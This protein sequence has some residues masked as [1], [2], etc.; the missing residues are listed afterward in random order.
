MPEIK[1]VIRWKS[2]KE[3]E[4]V[5]ELR[6]EDE[7]SGVYM[8]TGHHSVSGDD[9]L[10]YIGVAKDSTFCSRFRRADHKKYI[11]QEYDVKI[12]VGRI[13]SIDDDEGYSDKLWGS[14]I[15]D[16][17]ALLIHYHSPHHCSRSID[18]FPDPENDL[19][20]INIGDYGDLI[21]EISHDGLRK[22]GWS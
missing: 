15:E 13:D 12:Y 18:R 1:V 4:D 3:V 8:I 20:I 2:L 22:D 21:S 11:K 14:V 5:F 9:S 16:V 10:L 7:D 17:E 6:D 19:R